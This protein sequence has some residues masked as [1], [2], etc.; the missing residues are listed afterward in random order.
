MKILYEEYLIY[1]NI[2]LIGTIGGT[3]GMCI[4]FSFTGIIEHSAIFLIKKFKH[5][6]PNTI[7]QKSTAL[8]SLKVKES[9]IPAISKDDQLSIW[10]ESVPYVKPLG[11]DNKGT[12]LLQE[13]FNI[14]SVISKSIYV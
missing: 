9:V 11:E 5:K 4:G 13:N 10:I 8:K 7:L 6:I 2:H 12:D 3:L 1:D 14:S